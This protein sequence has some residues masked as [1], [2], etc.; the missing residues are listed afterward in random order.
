MSWHRILQILGCV[1][2]VIGLLGPWLWQGYDQIG[3]FNPSTR[4]METHYTKI[5]EVSPLY[6]REV[7]DGVLV[8]SYWFFEFNLSQTLSLSAFVFILGLFLC[9]LQSGL[10]KYTIL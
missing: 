9:S 10:N 6:A 2:V 5:I 1:F 3:T 4:K 7:I 8:R